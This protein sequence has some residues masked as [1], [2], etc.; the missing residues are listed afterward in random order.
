MYIYS[1]KNKFLT[2]CTYIIRNKVEKIF[3]ESLCF[4]NIISDTA[5]LVFKT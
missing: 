5:M 1:D 3:S 2:N 4:K